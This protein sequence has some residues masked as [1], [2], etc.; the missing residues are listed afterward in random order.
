M[1]PDGPI[2][3]A[4]LD[5][6]AD[7]PSSETD[8]PLVWA[9][10]VVPPFVVLRMTPETPTAHPVVVSMNETPWSIDDVPLV[11]AVQVVP[12][13]VVLR[14]TPLVPVAQHVLTSVQEM[15]MSVDDVPLVWAVHVVPPFEVF[16]MVPES[17]TAYAMVVD[18][19]ATA[20][21]VFEVPLVWAVHEAPPSV[22]FW[23][24]P[25]YPTTHP[26]R[27]SANRIPFTDVIPEIVVW[28]H[29]VPPS[30]VNAKEPLALPVPPAY[31]TLDETAWID[32]RLCDRSL[33][34]HVDERSEFVVSGLSIVNVSVA[35]VATLAVPS[36]T[37]E[38]ETD[39]A[40]M[41]RKARAT[42]EASALPS[43]LFRSVVSVN[44]Y[45]V[46]F[47]RFA[48][49]QVIVVPPVSAI[50]VHRFDPVGAPLCVFPVFVRSNVLL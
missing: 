22:V 8:V 25:G 44:V 4:T 1:V 32:W 36:V 11:W 20:S 16:R 15:A 7:T 48:C 37:L 18:T 38:D 23:I 45:H 35:V 40:P 27:T 17:P 43:V 10:Q 26:V 39:G 46:F 41:M 29:V 24:T 34:S 19:A 42:L 13:F 47:V 14:M 9:V 33:L 2:A 30:C 12:P 6:M 50:A 28:N 49:V 21:R 3:Y 5:E 31:A